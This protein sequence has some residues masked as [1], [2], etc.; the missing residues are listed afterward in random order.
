MIEIKQNL[1]YRLIEMGY[2]LK[3][4]NRLLDVTNESLIS[5]LVHMLCKENDFYLHNFNQIDKQKNDL[6]YIC[7]EPKSKHLRNPK[8]HL[9][10]NFIYY[11]ML[12]ESQDNLSNEE[13]EN[14]NHESSVIYEKSLID[15]SIFYWLGLSV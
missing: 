12:K 3:M 4:I 11:K 8:Y 1:Q 5:P 6:C 7:E 10:Y 9:P 14:L 13:I 2:D 15:N